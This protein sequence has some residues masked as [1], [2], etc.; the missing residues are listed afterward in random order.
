MFL[1]WRNSSDTSDMGRQ[2]V[3]SLGAVTKAR[4]PAAVL[5]RDCFSISSSTVVHVA[6]CAVRPARPGMLVLVH[7]LDISLFTPKVMPVTHMFNTLIES[8]YIN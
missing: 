6:R 8:Q 2:T 1:G 7:T 3:K 5:V 4:S